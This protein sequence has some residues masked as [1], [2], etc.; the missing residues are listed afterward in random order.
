M[1]FSYHVVWGHYSYP[2]LRAL[3]PIAATKSMELESLK[4]RT[5]SL[6]RKVTLL[7]PDTLSSDLLEEQIRYVL[8]YNKRDEI[9]ILSR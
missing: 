4:F 1:Y 3:R 8:G 7:R 6:E 2:K 5:A 9:V